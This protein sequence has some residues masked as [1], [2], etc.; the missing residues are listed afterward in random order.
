MLVVMEVRRAVTNGKINLG[1][2][3]PYHMGVGFANPEI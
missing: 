3:V 2:I 1:V